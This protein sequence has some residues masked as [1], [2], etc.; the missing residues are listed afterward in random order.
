MRKKNNE[1]E[2][3]RDRSKRQI[4]IERIDEQRGNETD[5][6][7]TEEI[8]EKQRKEIEATEKVKG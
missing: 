7:H 8:E 4:M 1:I 6:T 5:K 3:H 2:K